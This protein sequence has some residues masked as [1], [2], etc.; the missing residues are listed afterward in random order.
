MLGLDDSSDEEEPPQLPKGNSGGLNSLFGLHTAARRRGNDTFQWVKPKKTPGTVAQALVHH[1][2]VHLWR[3][4]TGDYHT[5]GP[6]V[7]ALMSTAPLQL[8][9]YDKQKRVLMGI[10]LNADFKFS[11]RCECV[12]EWRFEYGWECGCECGCGYGC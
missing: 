10:P 12:R 7:A 5:V 11:L 6:A 4:T 8:V 9:C 3:V 2:P 1:S